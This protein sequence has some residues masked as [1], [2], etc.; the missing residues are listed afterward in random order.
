MKEKLLL[1]LAK[2][3][4]GKP[5]A[6]ALTILQL[7]MEAVKTRKAK[8]VTLFVYQQLPAQWRHPEGPATEKEFMDTIKSGEAFLK[9]L[10]KL[11]IF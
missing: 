5:M 4:L 7:V 1:W 11:S 8:G 9:A 10:H 6:A 3:S 2:I